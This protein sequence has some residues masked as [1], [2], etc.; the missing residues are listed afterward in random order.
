VLIRLEETGRETQLLYVKENTKQ[1]LQR[2]TILHERTL[3]IHDIVKPLIIQ[4]TVYIKN[5]EAAIP[6]INLFGI[7]WSRL[8]NLWAKVTRKKTSP[9]VS[10]KTSVLLAFSMRTL[11]AL[12]KQIKTKYLPLIQHNVS[13]KQN[14][15]GMKKNKTNKTTNSEIFFSQRPNAPRLRIAKFNAK[16]LRA[17]ASLSLPEVAILAIC[18]QIPVF[19]AGPIIGASLNGFQGVVIGVLIGTFF[20]FMKYGSVFLYVK[21]KMKYLFRISEEKSTITDFSI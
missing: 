14:K 2:L 12:E 15:P 9:T 7:A 17:A 3:H 8:R 4:Q 1:H 11:K 20:E 10:V 18:S 6:K 19:A 13:S 16:I 5:L 21:L